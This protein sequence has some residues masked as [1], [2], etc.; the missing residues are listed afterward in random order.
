MEELL[1]TVNEMVKGLQGYTPEFIESL[2]AMEWAA[3]HAGLWA[4][5][6]GFAIGIILTVICAIL[7]KGD[8]DGWELGLVFSILATTG[9]IIALIVIYVSFAVFRAAPVAYV[10]RGLL[11]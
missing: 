8:L 4:A 9:A 6:V 5:W 11:P 7:T 10:V 3:F 2:V 1:A